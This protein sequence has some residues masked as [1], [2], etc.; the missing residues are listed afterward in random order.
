LIVKYSIVI[1][2]SFFAANLYGQAPVVTNVLNAGIGDRT[3]AP[4]SVVYIYGTFP[5][6]TAKNFSVTVG[7]V[8]G[9]VNAADSVGYITAVLPAAAPLGQQPLVVSYQG[10]SSN[11]YPVT[12]QPYAPEFQTVTVVPVT[13]TGPQFP[14]PSYF[15]IAHSDLT[16]VTPAAPAAPGERLVTILSGVG[17]TNP[18]VKL[19]GINSFESLAVEPVVMVGPASAPIYRAG[20][21]GATVE[22]E[23]F[24]PTTAP[25]GY[26]QVFL[27]VAGYRSNIVNIPIATRPLVTAVLNA[28]S[29]RSPGTVAPGS[30][31]SIFG[32]GF[33]PLDNL[34]AFPGTNVNGTTINMNNTLA[35]IFALATVEGQINALVPDEFPT[36]GTVNLTIVSNLGTS[37]TFPV[38]LAP[39]V[40]GIFFFQDPLVSTRRNA[41]AL[42]G[43]TAWIAMPTSTAAGIGIPNNCAALSALSTC[44]QPAHVGDVLQVFVTGLGIATPGGVPGAAILPTGQVAPPNGP[45]YL[46]VNTPSV[47]IG[48]I[49]VKVQF[50]GIAP[51]FAG[52]YQVNVPVPAG[53][54]SGDDVPITIQMPGSIVDTA[55]IAVAP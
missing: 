51:G 22:V 8:E 48:G 24:V 17:A 49:P 43:N 42:I 14:L 15:P 7:G 2:L 20:S 30:I 21:S 52:L 29:F 36:S 55:T 23:F 25:M 16:P 11:S 39:A 53:V 9:Y 28:G 46:T 1:G 33:G 4:L 40:P 19:G 35:P 47:T 54:Q 13:A 41:A 32:I 27:T 50:S 10:A 37:A 34:I 31:I 12:L 44:G 38:T 26:A 18:P 3:F 5:V 6:G 45:L